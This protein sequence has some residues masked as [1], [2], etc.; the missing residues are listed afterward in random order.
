MAHAE[1]L[2][3]TETTGK[4]PLGGEPSPESRSREPVFSH[5]LYNLAVIL[6][7]AWLAALFVLPPRLE[8]HARLLELEKTL[9]QDVAALLDEEVSFRSAILSVENDPFYRDEAHRYVLGVRKKDEEFLKKPPPDF[10]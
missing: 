9:H 1:G 3:P 5:E 8:R 7:C 4:R 6:L 10:R 2:S